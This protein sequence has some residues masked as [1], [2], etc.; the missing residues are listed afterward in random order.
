VVLRRR[1]GV[2]G[3]KS[4]GEKAAA[5]ELKIYKSFVLTLLQERTPG[6]EE[7]TGKGSSVA[8]GSQCHEK[9][10]GGSRKA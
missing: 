2:E 6:K 10:T 1:Q 7:A 3:G 9:L 4:R 8:Q 5:R